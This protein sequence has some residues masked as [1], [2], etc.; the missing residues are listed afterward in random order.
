MGRGKF[1]EV[2]WASIGL[3]A[4]L[5]ALGIF[6]YNKP[7]PRWTLGKDNLSAH[8][9]LWAG[10]SQTRPSFVLATLLHHN[11]HQTPEKDDR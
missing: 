9:A 2:T 3:S 4:A 8:P 7:C 6:E 1:T 11:I 10:V 5:T